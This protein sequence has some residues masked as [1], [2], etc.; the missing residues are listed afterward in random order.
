MS[1]AVVVRLLR[2]DRTVV[3][4]ALIGVVVLAWG[5]LLLGAGPDASMAS[6]GDAMMP[7]PW[8]RATFGITAVMWIAMMVAMMLPSA[9]PM[10]LLFAVI[11]RKREGAVAPLG[12]TAL[13][14]L[15]YLTIWAGFS[16]ATTVVQWGLQQAMLLSPAMATGSTA[17]TG[18]L[19]LLAGIYQ[20]TPLKQACLRQ[21]R[22]PLDFL[23]RNWRSGK[24][25]AFRMGLRHG[26]FCIGCCWAMMALLFVGG[27]MNLL[28]VAALAAF[29]L[30]ERLLPAGRMPSRTAGLGLILGGGAML[31]VAI[32]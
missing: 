31:L 13:F 29:V 22:S 11:D 24:V 4:S 25:G 20:L 17:L 15:A 26:V 18:I 9:A 7:T 12:M 2:R 3:V 19:L 27:V 14:A 1:D 30:A 8:T 16:I 5:Y 28:W 6:M 10:I 21:C 32:A 23:T